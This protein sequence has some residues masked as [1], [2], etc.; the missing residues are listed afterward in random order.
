M[1]YFSLT[2]GN[3][4]VLAGASTAP[5]SAFLQGNRVYRA[6]PSLFLLSLIS[7]SVSGV[8]DIFDREN[9]STTIKRNAWEYIDIWFSSYSKG[10]RQCSAAQG[11][12]REDPGTVGKVNLLFG[13]ASNEEVTGNP[14][15]PLRT[16]FLFLVLL[17]ASTK[18]GIMGKSAFL[19][20]CRR[21]QSRRTCIFFSE[22]G[23]SLM[24]PLH[25]LPPGCGRCWVPFSGD[26][27]PSHPLL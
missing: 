1:T 21:F 18:D 26:F 17:W 6:E 27:L 7:V 15:S 22:L 14:I 11:W 19:K 4:A 23:W 13:V 25:P 16:C 24:I 8:F 2:A 12:A 3:T 9:N 5:S 10:S 20:G